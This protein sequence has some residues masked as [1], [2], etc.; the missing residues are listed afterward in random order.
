MSVERIHPRELLRYAGLAQATIGTGRT[1]HIAG[2]GAMDAQFN[3]HG[4]D[5][6][7]QAVRALANLQ[8]ALQAAGATFDNLV[9]TT[10]YIKD[11]S[12]QAQEAIGRAMQTAFDGRP[13]PDHAMTMFGVSA[14]GSALMLVEISAVASI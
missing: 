10:V 6:Y 7:S 4:A 12:L 5:H 3:V 9:S 1:V 11:I 14:L 2:Q 8:L 13:I